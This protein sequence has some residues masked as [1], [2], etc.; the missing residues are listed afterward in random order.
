MPKFGSIF[1]RRWRFILPFGTRPWRILVLW[2]GTQVYQLV[3]WVMCVFTVDIVFS[4]NSQSHFTD[5]EALG[6]ELLSCEFSWFRCLT[7]WASTFRNLLEPGRLFRTRNFIVNR[8]VSWHFQLFWTFFFNSDL[9]QKTRNFFWCVTPTRLMIAMGGCVTRGCVASV[10]L[11]E[12]L[13]LKP[14]LAAHLSIYFVTL[15]RGVGSW[16]GIFHQPKRVSNIPMK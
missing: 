14:L 8:G 3:I 4:L 11:L 5:A 1:G 16:D 12:V 9:F 10:S 2:Q 7:F 15:R 6:W 13:D